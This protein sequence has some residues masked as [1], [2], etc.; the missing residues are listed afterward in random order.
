MRHEGAGVFFFDLCFSGEVK[1]TKLLT[2]NIRTAENLTILSD[3]PSLPPL[4]PL[5]LSQYGRDGSRGGEKIDMT[6]K[7][8]NRVPLSTF[9]LSLLL[10]LHVPVPPACLPAPIFLSSSLLSLFSSLP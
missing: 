10:A 1:S 8:S 5:L 6:V 3:M 9:A 4:S 7:L 2:F